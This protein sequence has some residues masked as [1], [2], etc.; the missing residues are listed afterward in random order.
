MSRLR[1]TICAVVVA[2]AFLAPTPA[3]ASSLTACGDLVLVGRS[4][5]SAL[6]Q[7]GAASGLRSVVAP[8]A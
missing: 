7:A 4:G 5:V 3:A 8:A 1:A 6:D 2:G